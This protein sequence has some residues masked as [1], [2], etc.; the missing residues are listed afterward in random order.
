MFSKP[1]IRMLQGG[2]LCEAVGARF[3]LRSLETK[4]QPPGTPGACLAWLVGLWAPWTFP[5]GM[6]KET[7][8]RGMKS[9]QV[10]LPVILHSSEHP[11]EGLTCLESTLQ[12][13]VIAH[14]FW[15]VLHSNSGGY[16]GS[17]ISLLNRWNVLVSP[18]EARALA[19]GLRQVRDGACAGPSAVGGG[20]GWGA[21]DTCRQ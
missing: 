15:F 8:W 17:G 10:H 7:E 5:G 20:L 13:S 9:L 6:V 14:I 21:G 19:Q 16:T 4:V 3:R 11:G 12:F 1:S 2:R 18:E